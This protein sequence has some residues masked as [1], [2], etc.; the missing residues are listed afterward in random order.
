MI[1]AL[2]ACAAS[3]PA[4]E[5]LHKVLTSASSGIH[6]DAWE[7]T[8]HATG[9]KG[10]AWSVRKLTLHGGKQE[11]CELIVVDNGKL[12]ITVVP[13]RGMSVLEVTDGEL[14]LSKTCR[15]ALGGH[16]AVED[17]ASPAPLLAT[18]I[19]SV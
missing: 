19:L 4:A 16:L 12:K 3:S 17:L 18:L 11:G 1:A 10:A 13:T 6:V 14:K 7:Q 15:A 8:G 2:T 9:A 5:P